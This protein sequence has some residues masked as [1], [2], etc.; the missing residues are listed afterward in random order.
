MA[1]GL[2]L[3]ALAFIIHQ[4][5]TVQPRGRRVRRQEL[6]TL[7]ADG[8]DVY[9][10]DEAKLAP[11]ELTF[12][13]QLERRIDLHDRQAAASRIAINNVVPFKRSA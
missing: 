3:I 4:L 8:L 13:R 1:F 9:G 6:P 12:L 10:I 5:R 11:E 2:A 7:R